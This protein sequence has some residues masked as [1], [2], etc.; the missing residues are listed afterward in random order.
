MLQSSLH[1]IFW[2]RWIQSNLAPK[3]KRE[4]LR[5]KHSIDAEILNVFF[6]KRPREVN[7]S[8]AL[9]IDPLAAAAEVGSVYSPTQFILCAAAI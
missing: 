7:R 8:S 6:Y 2:S 1:H 4:L 3:I 5:A 9:A